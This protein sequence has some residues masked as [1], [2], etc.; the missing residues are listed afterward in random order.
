MTREELLAQYSEPSKVLDHGMVRLVDV[1]GDDTAVVQ[2][3]RTSY[4]AGTQTASS[5]EN[6]LRYLMR[7]QHTS[8]FEGAVAKLHIKC[9]ILVARQLV[10]HRTSSMN[11]VS[12]RYSEVR[13]EFYLPDL[14]RFQE[15]AQDNKQGS[16]Q[17]LATDVQERDRQLV[18]ES[19][20]HSYRVYQELLDSGLAREVART[21][22]PVGTYTEFYF[23]QNLHNLLHMLRLR[24][25]P[26]AQKETREFA[27]AI[28]EIVAQWVPLTWKAFL[29]YR[30]ETTLFTKPEIAA[31]QSYFEN[32]PF[33]PKDILM[34]S[35]LKGRELK[36]FEAKLRKLSK[37]GI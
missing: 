1:M 5:D 36:E 8:P 32:N 19:N 11:E 33:E 10:R 21:V 6:L 35:D 4:G 15:Q 25:D 7:H 20:E 29:D 22:L 24:M 27:N 30:V 3:A 23:M 14:E 13:D 34:L 18:Q 37:G 26:H 9:P 12:Y 31:L 2:M 17:G 16:G 28:A